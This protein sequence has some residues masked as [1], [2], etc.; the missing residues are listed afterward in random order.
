MKVKT[1]SNFW[2]DMGIL[3]AFVLTL[4]TGVVLWLVLPEGRGSSIVLFWGLM[5]SIWL[6]IHVW[7]GVVM[8]IGAGTH[9]LIH[10]RWVSCVGKRYFQKLAKQA[11]INFTL[12]TLLFVSFFLANLTGLVIWLLL[13]QGGY[14]GGRNAAF[15]QL[16]L[17]QERAV[18]GDWHLWSGL[19]LIVVLM[20]HITNHWQWI[21]CML[22]RYTK[23]LLGNSA[24][25]TRRNPGGVECPLG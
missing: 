13:P 23:R 22:K 11:R 2:L 5:K 24:V 3:L 15:I 18:W 14:Q 17:G 16:F 4:F 1:K 25:K 10:W 7:S 9:L 21:L 8:F 20:A 12:N 19:I 6:D